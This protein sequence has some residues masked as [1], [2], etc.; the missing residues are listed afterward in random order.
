MNIQY[1]GCTSVHETQ[2]PTFY[3]YY[4]NITQCQFFSVVYVVVHLIDFNEYIHSGQGY[5]IKSSYVN[6]LIVGVF[7]HDT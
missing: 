7:R 6:V 3:H 5:Y 2:Q 1:F 4:L